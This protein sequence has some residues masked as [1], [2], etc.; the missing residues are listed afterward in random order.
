MHLHLWY[1]C[2]VVLT[3]RLQGKR[4]ATYLSSPS[5]KETA[6]AVKEKS[7]ISL[8]AKYMVDLSFLMQLHCIKECREKDQ[9]LDLVVK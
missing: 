2:V 3:R 8:V 5:E 7:R 1:S 6:A 9:P 4:H